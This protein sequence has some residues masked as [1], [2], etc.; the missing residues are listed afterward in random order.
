[1]DGE[2]IAAG[3]ARKIGIVRKLLVEIRFGRRHMAGRER[4][5]IGETDHALGHRAQVVQH[6]WAELDLAKRHAP[7]FGLAFSVVLEQQA[8]AARHQQRVQ[9][10]HTPVALHFSQ[11]RGEV[12]IGRDG[13]L[14]R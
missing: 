8:A 6:R 12:A 10:R 11:A 5:A 14:C 13:L 9:A 3:G 2:P 4:N 7:V 1:M